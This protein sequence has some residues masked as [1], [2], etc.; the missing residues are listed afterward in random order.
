VLP[1]WRL[2]HGLLPRLPKHA[3]VYNGRLLRL[4]DSETTSI[5][6]ASV[7]SSTTAK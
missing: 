1:A 5:E 2:E 7:T 6:D 4:D 3:L